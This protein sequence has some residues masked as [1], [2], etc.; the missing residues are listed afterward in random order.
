MVYLKGN[1]GRQLSVKLYSR[2]HQPCAYVEGFGLLNE[3]SSP[4]DT[5]LPQALTGSMQSCPTYT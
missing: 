4:A 3:G 2:K 5:E 1:A